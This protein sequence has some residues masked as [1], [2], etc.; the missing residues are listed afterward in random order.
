MTGGPRYWNEDSQRWEEADEDGAAD[1]GTGA[2]GEPA[3]DEGG[4]PAVVWPTPTVVSAGDPGTG[5][6]APGGGGAGPGD[7]GAPVADGTGATAAGTP[8]GSAAPAAP[9]VSPSAPTLTGLQWP[10]PVPPPPSGGVTPPPWTPADPYPA[11]A[12]PAGTPLPAPGA[13]TGRRRLWLVVGG[14]A[15]V[16]VTLGLVATLAARS[17]DG[18]DDRAGG[19][20]VSASPSPTD[21]TSAPGAQGVPPSAPAD[22]TTAS[23]PSPLADEPPAG[24]ELFTDPEGFTIVRPEGW[25]REDVDSK[26]GIDVVN[27]YSADRTRRI[28]VFEVSE[29]S[30]AE[31]HALFLSDAVQKAPGFTEL[32]LTD[33]GSGGDSVSRLEYLVDSL[34]GQPDVGPWHVVDERFTAAD[35]KVYAVAAYGP[36]AEDRET[37]RQVLRTA[38]GGFCPPDTTCGSGTG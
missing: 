20:T 13:G 7:P 37:R 6:A 30:P 35:G 11:P 16:G 17:G 8:A 28:Q 25:T 34:T 10:G 3:A 26:Y 24:Y 1:P 19:P 33:G 23:A 4:A 9:D 36:D 21:A 12:H 29:A 15:A 31:S 2:R 38:L 22:G 32:S 18:T 5:P 14:A 27:Y